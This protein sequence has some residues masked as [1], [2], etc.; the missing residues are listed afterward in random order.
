MSPLDLPDGWRREALGALVRFDRR[1]VNASEIVDDARYVGLEHVTGT[2]GQ[3][4]S[5]PAA[6]AALRSAKF[7]F[8]PGDLLYGKL[9]PNLRKCALVDVAG[10]CS[11][12]I[13][14]LTPVEAADGPMLSLLLRSRHFAARVA[15]LVSGANLPRVNVRDLMAVPI[16]VPPDQE[17]ERLRGLAGAALRARRQIDELATTIMGLEVAAATGAWFPVDEQASGEVA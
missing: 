16:P 10:V 13:L 11:T 1:S 7:R 17:R 9:R 8:S 4:T 12:D 6:S 3:W 5:V 2:T 15:V 14:P